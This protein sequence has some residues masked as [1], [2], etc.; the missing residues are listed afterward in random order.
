[1]GVVGKA[2][3][4]QTGA[5]HAGLLQN[6]E[7]QHGPVLVRSLFKLGQLRIGQ[8]PLGKAQIDPP[9]QLLGVQAHAVPTQ[10]TEGVAVGMAD[11][12]PVRA[13]RKIGAAPG[14]NMN[15]GQSLTG[16]FPVE[17]FQQG[18]SGLVAGLPGQ[19]A[20]GE[21]HRAS[22]MLPPSER[23]IPFFSRSRAIKTPSR[24]TS[25]PK[26]TITIREVVMGSRISTAP[27]MALI[28][29]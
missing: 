2:P 18:P 7:G 23:G 6:P 14:G 15:G 11:G 21:S 9:V 8:N 27:T 22:M 20:G 17:R 16:F 24:A 25:R 10:H 19:S 1:M 3:Q 12:E 5:L 26:S 29:A 4:A 28:R 13:A